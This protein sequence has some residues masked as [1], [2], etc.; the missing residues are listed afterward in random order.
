M[1]RTSFEAMN[2]SVAQCLE[3]VGEWWSMLIIRD[4]FLGVRR[5]DDFQARLGISRN[6]LNQRLNGLVEHGVLTRVP[7]QEH[8]PRSEYRLTDKGRDLWSVLTSM[9]QWGDRW[10]APN[11]APVEVV[12]TGCGHVSSAVSVCSECGE[13]LDARAVH[14]IAG[15][16]AREEDF[17][18]TSVAHVSF[19]AQPRPRRRAA[20]AKIGRARR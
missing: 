2:C 9:R 11:G 12:H 15:P 4:A 20:P 1:Q 16:G 5:F 3:V 19:E 13:T 17:E 8:P 18:R 6:I 10:A 7:Y 14:A